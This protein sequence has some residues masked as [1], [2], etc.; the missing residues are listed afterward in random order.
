MIMLGDFCRME[1]TVGLRILVTAYLESATSSKRDRR[2]LAVI[3]INI[4]GQ[5]W[6]PYELSGFQ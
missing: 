3:R 5:H 4:I 1:S 6:V 2:T